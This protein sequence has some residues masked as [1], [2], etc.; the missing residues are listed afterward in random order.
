M[1]TISIP[2]IKAYSEPEGLL[3]YGTNVMVNARFSPMFKQNSLTKNF[4][5]KASAVREA[6]KL[7]RRVY[8]PAFTVKKALDLSKPGYDSG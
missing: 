7:L 1:E 4:R 3:G 2:L 8:G 5:P 6:L